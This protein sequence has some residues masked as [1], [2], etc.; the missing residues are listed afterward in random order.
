MSNTKFLNMKFRKSDDEK[1]NIGH[2]VKLSKIFT[3]SRKLAKKNECIY[4]GKEVT[5]FCNSHSIPAFCLR[6]I[7][8]NGELF[9]SNVF[10]NMPLLPLDKGV[11]NAG[12]FQILCHECDSNVFQEY[13]NPN[14]YEKNPTPK[15]VA[16]IAMKNYLRAISK[17]LNEYAL[18]DI[19]KKEFPDTTDI[20]N[21]MQEIQKMDLKEYKA[22]YEK[23]KRISVKNWPEAYHVFCYE[24]L[25]Y[26]VPMAFQGMVA[27]LSDLDGQ[28]INDLYYENPKYII[29]EIHICVFPLN[30]SSIVMMFV[31]SRFKRYR[32]FYKKFC[33]LPLDEKLALISYIILLYSEDVFFSKEIPDD[34]LHDEN[35]KDVCG[36]TTSVLSKDF[37]DVIERAKDVFDLSKCNTIPNLL[38]EK[39]KLR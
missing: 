32:K 21:Y 23:A 14:N 37:V 17:R 39:Y 11:N 31:D 26:V 12:T 13:E 6:N 8:K 16:Q 15:M 29:E 3:D 4:C 38:S 2:K 30:D 24:R 9:Y 18:F 19:T 28:I 7:S 25:N 35:I 33:V 10:I 22:G 20:L 1:L 5:S 27:L 34:I 36:Q